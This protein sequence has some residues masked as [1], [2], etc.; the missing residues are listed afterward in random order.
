MNTVFVANRAEIAHRVIRTARSLGYRTAVACSPA[1]RDLPFA[2]A[3]DR[4]VVWDG[5]S[6]VG[7]TYLD[8][9]RVVAAALQAGADAVHPGYGFLSE[10]AAFAERVLAAGLTTGEGDSSMTFWRRRWAVQSRSPM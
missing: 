2:A 5:P 8:A 4:V 6:D 1:D 10:N 7:A 3:A 9:E